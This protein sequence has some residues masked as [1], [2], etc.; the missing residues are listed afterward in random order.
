MWR[1]PRPPADNEEPCEWC[2]APCKPGDNDTVEN[3]RGDVFCDEDCL[4]DWE[5]ENE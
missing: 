4:A 5:V 3:S 1:N 2:G